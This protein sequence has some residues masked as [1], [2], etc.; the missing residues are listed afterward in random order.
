MRKPIDG[1]TTRLRVDLDSERRIEGGAIGFY[2]GVCADLRVS[3]SAP[4]A[5]L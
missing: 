1:F 2:D 3:R 4:S 5:A